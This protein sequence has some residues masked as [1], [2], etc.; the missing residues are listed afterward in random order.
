MQE[1]TS[2][3]ETAD[4]ATVVLRRP[5]IQACGLIPERVAS[6]VALA[7]MELGQDVEKLC[8]AMTRR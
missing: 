5:I 4:P 8:S 7:A 6:A 1:L 3:A 2:H